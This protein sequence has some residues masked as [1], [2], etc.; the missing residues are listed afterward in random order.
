MKIPNSPPPIIRSN[1]GYSR[2]RQPGDG[3]EGH[4][5]RPESDGAQGHSFRIGQSLL[6]RKTARTGPVW[7]D[8]PMNVQAAQ[9]EKSDLKTFV[10]PKEVLFEPNSKVSHL[11]STLDEISKMLKEAKRPLIWL[12]HG[13][14][15]AGGTELIEP[16]LKATGAPALVTWN[17]IDMIES[18]HPQV[19]GRAGLYGQR[20]SNFILQNCDF[21]LAVGTRLA[22][23]QVGYDMSE[24]ARAAKM[25]VVDRDPLEV[26][27]HGDRVSLPVCADAKYFISTFLEKLKGTQLPSYQSWLERCRGYATKYPPVGPE[28]ADRDGF[29]NSYPFMDRLS[30]VMKPDQCVVTDMGT[31]LLSGHQVLSLKKGQR[32]MTST[33]LGEMGYGLPAAIGVSFARNR[34]EVLCLNCD[35]GMM[36]NLQELQTIAHHQLPIKVII[37]N[38]DGYLMIKHTQKALFEG[39]YAGTNVKS[40]VSCPDYSKLATAFGFPSYRIRSWSDF[41]SVMP[42]VLEAKG[43]VFCE[44]F[45]HPEQPLVP[46]LA[47]APQKDGSIISPPLEDLSPFLSREE[48][49]E[50]MIIGMHPKS[51]RIGTS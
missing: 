12:G 8:V 31:A 15:L 14:R 32:L 45:M 38:N 39:R 35:G 9:V 20:A 49:R 30:K 11:D 19:F 22:I 21:L 43:P 10:P 5:V 42:Q 3:P 40:G 29:I 41:D 51:E 34:G 4:Q 18:Q 48:I 50:A 46:K 24:F 26:G 2:L 28:H 13:I 37:F 44:V 47:L 6:S 25:V 27:K 1:L 36:M 23:P 33:G 7:L 16:L 17:G